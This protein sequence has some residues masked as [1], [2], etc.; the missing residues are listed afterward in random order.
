MN[1]FCATIIRFSNEVHCSNAENIPRLE[2]KQH[3]AET[4]KYLMEQ[5]KID[6]LI[7]V[8]ITAIYIYIYNVYIIIYYTSS[9]AQGGGGSFRIGNL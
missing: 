4:P 6:S 3:P 9:T 2:A 1:L 5:P 8:Y 7:Y